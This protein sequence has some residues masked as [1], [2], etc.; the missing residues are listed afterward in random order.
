MKWIRRTYMYTHTSSVRKI[1]AKNGPKIAVWFIE[2]S[3][4]G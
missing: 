2:S 1:A 4:L 3:S